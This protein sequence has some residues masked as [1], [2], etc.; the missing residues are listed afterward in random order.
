MMKTAESEELKNKMEQAG[1]IVDYKEQ[2]KSSKYRIAVGN[3]KF[4]DYAPDIKAL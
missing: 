1:L 2:G 4:A 3:G